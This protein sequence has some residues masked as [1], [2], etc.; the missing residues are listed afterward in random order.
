L[1]TARSACSGVSVAL[2][3]LLP[4]FGSGVVEVAVADACHANN[5]RPV[6]RSDFADLFGRAFR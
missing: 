6:G 3:V 1:K 2:L 4:G 5:P